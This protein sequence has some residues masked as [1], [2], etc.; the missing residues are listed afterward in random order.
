MKCPECDSLEDFGFFTVKGYFI[1]KLKELIGDKK[2]EEY[3]KNNPNIFSNLN[4]EDP[5]T[6]TVLAWKIYLEKGE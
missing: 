2:A 4:D 5:S 6:A 3:I 1:S